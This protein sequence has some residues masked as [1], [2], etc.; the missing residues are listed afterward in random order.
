MQDHHVLP[1]RRLPDPNSAVG[2]HRGNLLPVWVVHS[3]ED[4][5]GVAI[6]S[7]LELAVC[8]RALLAHRPVRGDRYEPC[9]VRAECDA[10][11]LTR[12]APTSGEQR[13]RGRV[14]E[15]T[16]RSSPAEVRPIPSG[17]KAKGHVLKWY[18]SQ[19]AVDFPDVAS[20]TTSRDQLSSRHRHASQLSSRLAT[21]PGPSNLG[22]FKQARTWSGSSRNSKVHCLTLAVTQSPR[23][24]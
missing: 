20:Y 19:A 24:V 18:P 5:A 23:Q 8:P 14:S 13:A 6:M 3:R 9:P 1:T 11:N 4:V 22:V 16:V 2:A 15:G 7:G 12:V 17:P 10:G 21:G